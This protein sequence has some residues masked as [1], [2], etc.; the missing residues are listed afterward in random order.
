M[1]KHTSKIIRILYHISSILMVVFGT[2]ELYE[3]F[4]VRA[5]YDPRRSV[6]EALFWSTFAVFHLCNWY[7][8]KHKNTIDT[9]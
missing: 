2:A 4:V 5:A 7:V 9:L 6:V 8:R 3:I 1:K